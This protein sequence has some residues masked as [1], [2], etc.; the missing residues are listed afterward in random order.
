[1]SNTQPAGE[2]DKAKSSPAKSAGDGTAKDQNESQKNT[3]KKD[4]DKNGKA[5]GEAEAATATTSTWTEAEEKE[6]CELKT[7][8]KTWADIASKLGKPKKEVQKRYG[9]LRAAN[10]K[11]KKG[12]KDKTESAKEAEKRE[13]VT[14]GPK[15]PVVATFERVDPDAEID[16]LVLAAVALITEG[17]P[18]SD[19]ANGPGSC[20]SIN[21]LNV[22]EVR[23]RISMRTARWKANEGTPGLAACP[24]P[25]VL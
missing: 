22:D 7:G 19:E 8:G 11:N 14:A 17:G 10:E 6:L 1:M 12:E 25:G 3:E 20:D 21:S 15:L 24:P 16:P 23:M 13:N 2:G 5:E 18:F 4:E 9:E